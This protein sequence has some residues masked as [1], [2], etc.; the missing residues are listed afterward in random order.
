[1]HPDLSNLLYTRYP[2]IFADKDAPPTDSLMGF[3]FC[4]GDGWFFI[5]D[6]LCRCI[7]NHVEWKRRTNPDFSVK[8]VQVKEKF[9][10]LRFYI[11]GGDEEVYGMIKMAECMSRNVCEVT[12]DIG[13]TKTSGWWSTRSPECQEK[14]TEAQKTRVLNFVNKIESEKAEDNDF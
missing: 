7:Q 8:A 6:N 12:G 5:I 3:G 1:M 9:G 2:D 10:T 14:P 13:S 11:D 4:C